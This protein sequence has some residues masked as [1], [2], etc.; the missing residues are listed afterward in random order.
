MIFLL[1]VSA[2]TYRRRLRAIDAGWFSL[3]S[4]EVLGNFRHVMSG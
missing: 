2:G 4:F 3:V 1:L